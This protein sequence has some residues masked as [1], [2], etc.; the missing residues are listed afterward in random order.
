MYGA[1]GRCRPGSGFDSPK[2]SWSNVAIMFFNFRQ[3]NSGGHFAFDEKAGISVNVIVEA[4]TAEEA[5]SKAEQLGLYFDGCDN[6]QDCDCCG[7]RWYRQYSDSDGDK[8]PS[9]YGVAIRKNQKFKKDGPFHFKWING[10]EAFIHYKN[11]K[12]VPSLI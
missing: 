1:S 4:E 2:K 8:K 6:G 11:G 12:V 3:N 7:D 10:P 9:I 5:N